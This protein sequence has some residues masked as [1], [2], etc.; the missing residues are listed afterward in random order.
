MA[1]NHQSAQNQ[2]NRRH[3]HEGPKNHYLSFALSI[4]LTILA[5][6]VVNAQMGKTFTFLFIMVLAIIQATFQLAFWMHM[7]DRGHLYAIIGIV[8]GAFVALTGV[9]AAVYWI[10]W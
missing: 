10:W 2:S 5:F 3:S 8:F 4:L 7:K 6:V 1:A 9:V